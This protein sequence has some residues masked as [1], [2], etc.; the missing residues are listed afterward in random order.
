MHKHIFFLLRVQRMNIFS[1]KETYALITQDCNFA[2]NLPSFISLNSWSCCS[3]GLISAPTSW[4]KMA[5][6]SP[7]ALFRRK[8]KSPN[9]KTSSKRVVTSA[10]N[11]QRRENKQENKYIIKYLNMTSAETLTSCGA[12][13][14]CI[15]K[16]S[17]KSQSF[18]D[19]VVI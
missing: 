5:C 15:R 1:L 3:S 11:K 16:V 18:Y 2:S 19:L 9:Q 14:V 4:F 10:E 13:R 7:L 8:L 12:V 6:T 17:R